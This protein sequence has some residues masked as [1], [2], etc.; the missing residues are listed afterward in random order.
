MDKWKYYPP[1]PKTNKRRPYYPEARKRTKDQ[2]EIW[3]N[4]PAVKQWAKINH[5]L[6]ISPH[7]RGLAFLKRTSS[8]QAYGESDD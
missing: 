1:K 6:V 2:L 3:L 4:H 5:E 7:S 8:R